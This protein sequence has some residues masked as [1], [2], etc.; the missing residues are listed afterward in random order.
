M[1]STDARSLCKLE[2]LTSAGGSSLIILLGRFLYARSAFWHRLSVSQP[3]RPIH[4]RCGAWGYWAAF[5]ECWGLPK[6]PLPTGCGA[7]L[8][9]AQDSSP[10]A[11][12]PPSKAVDNSASIVKIVTNLMTPAADKV[13]RTRLPRSAPGISFDSLSACSASPPGGISR[14]EGPVLKASSGNARPAPR[15]RQPSPPPPG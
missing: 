6:E 12:G 2:Q 13:T 1:S 3:Y 4:C 7:V 11:E 15:S 9:T 14:D 10:E 5:R 8:S